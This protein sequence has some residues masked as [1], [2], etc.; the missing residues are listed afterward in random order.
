MTNESKE[1]DSQKS[2]IITF[3]LLATSVAITL[4]ILCVGTLDRAL[5]FAIYFASVGIPILA[6]HSIVILDGKEETL[7]IAKPYFAVFVIGVLSSACSLASVFFH[8]SILAGFSL[9]ILGI[10]CLIFQ[11]IASNYVIEKLRKDVKRIIEEKQKEGGS[12]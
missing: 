5:L 8:F 10:A 6:L 1:N 4:A 3:G 2:S 12:S 7:F 9:V 11:E